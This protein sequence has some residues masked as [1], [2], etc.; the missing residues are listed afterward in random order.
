[1]NNYEIKQL[2]KNAVQNNKILHSYM[3]IGSKLTQKQEIAIEFAKT[4]LCFNRGNTPCEGCKSCIEMNSSN[5][6]DF[7][8][9]RLLEDGATI[10]IEQIRKLQDDIVKKPIIS[11]RKVYII[12]NCDKMTV[13]S[14]K[15]FVENFRRATRVCYYNFVSRK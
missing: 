3:F 9:I 11:D 10:K 8:I 2:L 1:M 15:L 6:P 13:R 5:H 14:P 7:E 12:Q 4:I